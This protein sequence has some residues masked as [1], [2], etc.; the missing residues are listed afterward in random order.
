MRVRF[1]GAA[2]VCLPR[3]RRLSHPE[4]VAPG[5][6]PRASLWFVPDLPA[7]QPGSRRGEAS[8]AHAHRGEQARRI[9]TRGRP[10]HVSKFVTFN[11]LST[12]SLGGVPV[13]NVFNSGPPDAREPAPPPPLRPSRPPPHRPTRLCKAMDLLADAAD[14]LREDVVSILSEMRNQRH[15]PTPSP[16]EM[17]E[18][19]SPGSPGFDP[20]EPPAQCMHRRHA[21]LNAENVKVRHPFTPA[22]ASW[23]ARAARRGRAWPA[24][25]S[26]YARFRPLGRVRGAPTRMRSWSSS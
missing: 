12:G 25:A 11:K 16:S 21:V 18:P 13:S 24:R 4:Q 2:Q 6:Q 3:A 23:R 7:I 9:S 22:C 10:K 15:S 17:A 20:D 5:K 14:S 1:P 8:P 26:P 19:D